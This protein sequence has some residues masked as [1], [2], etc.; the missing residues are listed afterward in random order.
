[1]QIIEYEDKYL[2]DIRDLLVELEEYIVSID[3]DELD[4]V[5]KD[6]R[7][8]MALMELEEVNKNNGKC[9]I[10]VENN[11]AIGL[12]MGCI[13]PYD[14]KDYLDYK[15]PKKG[16]ITELIVSKKARGQGIGKVLMNKMEEYFKSLGCEYILLDVFAYNVNAIKFYEKEGYHS[17][18]YKEIKKIN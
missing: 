11:K 3:K 13:F 16:E 9:Y 6:Y 18:M 7:E 12:I 17:R 14:E 10:A 1:M 4:Q 5:G 8:K 2:E 15:C